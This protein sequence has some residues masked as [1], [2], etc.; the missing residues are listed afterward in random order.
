MDIPKWKKIIINKMNPTELLNFL[1]ESSKW[2]YFVIA[3]D[4]EAFNMEII[5]KYYLNYADGMVM[6][7][8]RKNLSEE[9]YNRIQNRVLSIL[10]RAEKEMELQQQRQND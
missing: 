1:R 4:S 9:D 7:S 5:E 2:D 8:L 3:V 10:K 6:S